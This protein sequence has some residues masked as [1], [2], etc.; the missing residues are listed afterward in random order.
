MT[1]RPIRPN[2]A[3]VA[4]CAVLLMAGCATI[5]G[6]NYVS[7]EEEWQLGRELETD[8]NGRLDLVNDAALTGYVRSVGQRMVQQ[9]TMAGQ[10]WRFPVVNDDEINAFNVPGGLVYVNTGLIARS[11]S[12]AEF[13]GALAHEIGHGV[14]RHGTRRYSQQQ[15]ANLVAGI[16]LGRNPGAVAQIGA[17]VAAA[18]AF[19]RFSRADERE[20]DQ[21]GVQLM[22]ATGYDP[23]GLA[24][25]LE[26]LMQEGGGGGG[27]FA[28]HP[29]PAERVTNVR[30]F[31]RNVNRQGLRMDDS[32]FAAARS[33]AA[34]Y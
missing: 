14:A 17:Q 32:G 4:A 30:A 13:A 6:A 5:G 21:L 16:L 29:N 12:A 27:F 1:P 3:V 25:L 28:S 10:T 31:A 34:R 19:A 18:G 20:A 9:T 22:A 24:R 8:L 26:R 7:L 23:E 11:G 2:R 33:R 15:D